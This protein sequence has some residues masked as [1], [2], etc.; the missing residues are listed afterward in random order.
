VIIYNDEF[1]EGRVLVEDYI[2]FSTKLEQNRTCYFARTEIPENSYFVLGDNRGA[3]TDSRSKSLGT[4]NDYAIFGK[5]VIK[6]WPLGQ[7]E[8]FDL[9]EYEFEKITEDIQ[10]RKDDL[11]AEGTTC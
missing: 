6:F 8:A 11:I 4:V 7:V 2:P 3:S 10:D 5:E 1:P 9:P